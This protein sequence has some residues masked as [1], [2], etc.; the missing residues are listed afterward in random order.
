MKH[1]YNLLLIITA[2]MLCASCNNEW[3]KE[4][5]RQLVSFKSPL[6]SKG[7]RSIYIRYK[8]DGK[9]TFQLPLIVSGSTVNSKNLKIHIALD[10]DTLNTMNK[11]RFGSRTELFYKQ[12]SSQY[13]EMPETVDIPAGESTALF[14]IDF[15][16]ANLDMV[17]KWVLPL[18]IEDGSSY[19]YTVNTR[20]YYRK[21]MLRIFPFNNYSGEYG[22]TAYKVY[23]K[24][25][26]TEAMPSEYRTGYVVNEN[27][28]F[29]YAGLVDE[30]RLDR[31]NY[32]IFVRFEEDK[33]DLQTKKATIY[34]DNPDERLNFVVKGQPSYS[35]EE[36]MDATL[37]YLKHVYVTLNME[38][39]YTDYTSVPGYPLNYIVKG[40][41]TMER[42][43][44]TQIPDEDQAIEW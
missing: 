39:E 2:L 28:V 38:Y 10:P 43:I 15:S 35:I 21:A 42:K 40:S 31:S 4:Q 1:I 6:D 13:F 44:N 19:G 29:F 3:E 41:L 23:F 16:L 34:T 37:P 36:M 27:T 26:E 30:D 12:L 11:E 5:F 9:V 25:N 8:P 24:G 22:A 20:R 32:K 7:T 14:P 17:D 33:I 18:N